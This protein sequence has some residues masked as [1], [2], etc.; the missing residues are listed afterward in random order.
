MAVDASCADLDE[1]CKRKVGNL[2]TKMDVHELSIW[3]EEESVQVII[4]ISQTI[5]PFLTTNVRGQA[6]SLQITTYIGWAIL[7]Q[8]NLS[9]RPSE[10]MTSRSKKELFL[11]DVVI[12]VIIEG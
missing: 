6:A 12:V 5:P 10:I 8:S 1:A 3:P 11:Q 4:M 9:I 7:V 2:T